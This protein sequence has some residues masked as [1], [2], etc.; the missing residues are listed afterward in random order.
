MNSVSSS[1]GFERA[2]TEQ[3]N[4]HA[5]EVGRT[6]ETSGSRC[7]SFGAYCSAKKASSGVLITMRWS[8]HRRALGVIETS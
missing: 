6:R 4:R 5:G 7:R 8:P 2:A 1:S 3:G